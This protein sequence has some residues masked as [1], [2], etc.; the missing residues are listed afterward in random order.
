LRWYWWVL[1][2]GWWW[3]TRSWCTC[4]TRI[5]ISV[6]GLLLLCCWWCL[7]RSCCCCLLLLYIC[8]ISLLV[9]INRYTIYYI[10]SSNTNSITIR[11]CSSGCSTNSWYLICNTLSNN[12]WYS[13][14]I[15]YN[16]LYINRWSLSINIVIY[17]Y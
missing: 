4:R 7:S 5:S 12:R 1:L 16:R 9:I 2:L 17:C 15:N 11:C 10:L 13:N 6:S 8:Y 14:W 3:I